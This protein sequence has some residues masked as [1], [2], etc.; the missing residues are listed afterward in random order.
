M[1]FKNSILNHNL[2][3]DNPIRRIPDTGSVYHST[4]LGTDPVT[5]GHD[6]SKPFSL[7]IKGPQAQSTP[8]MLLKYADNAFDIHPDYS[9]ELKSIPEVP[10]GNVVDTCPPEDIVNASEQFPVSNGAAHALANAR[11]PG[12]TSGLGFVNDATNAL[13]SLSISDD[14]SDPLNLISDIGINSMILAQSNSNQ[15]STANYNPSTVRGY[16][17]KINQQNSDKAQTTNAIIGSSIGKLFGPVGQLLG[18]M[19]GMMMPTAPGIKINS[20]AG[21]F[22]SDEL[23]SNF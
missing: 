6:L 15:N 9:D 3:L 4:I 21:D 20:D 16:F 17:N 2:S 1:S 12:D 7:T 19:G 10:T 22:K 14:V 11:T 23:P 13:S 8:K 18:A 5:Q